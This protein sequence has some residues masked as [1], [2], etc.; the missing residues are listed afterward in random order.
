MNDETVPR[1]GLDNRV[2]GRDGLPVTELV[3]FRGWF[4]IRRADGSATGVELTAKIPGYIDE[5][6]PHPTQ[7]AAERAARMAYADYRE[8]VRLLAETA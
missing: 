8:A 2:T 3:L 5:V 4:R 6:S 1:A 7:S